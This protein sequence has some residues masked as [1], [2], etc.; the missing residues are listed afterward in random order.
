MALDGTTPRTLLANLTI[1][2]MPT[3]VVIGGLMPNTAY[4]IQAA[5]WTLMGLGPT[6]A[7]VVYKMDESASKKNPYPTDDASLPDG[8]DGGAR[9]D[10]ADGSDPP[11]QDVTQVMQQTWFILLLGGILLAVLCLFIGALIVR[12]TLNRK[13]ALTA[14]N[15]PDPATGVGMDPTGMMAA[16]SVRGRHEV[17]WSRNGWSTNAKGSNEIDVQA[18]L[19]PHGA[20]PL[21]T[22]PEYAELLDHHHQHHHQSADHCGG[23]G[24]VNQNLSLS[25]FLPRKDIF[26]RTNSQQ[27]PHPAAYATTTLVARRQNGGLVVQQPLQQQQLKSL[28]QHPADGCGPPTSAAF[29]ASD[30]SG[31]TTDELADRSR[32]NYMSTV[33]AAATAGTAHKNRMKLLP[34]L[35]ELL[36]P[37]PRH[38]PPSP[39]LGVYDPINTAE[40]IFQFLIDQL[41]FSK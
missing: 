18:T 31:Y 21:L 24:G 5:A 25:S 19:L 28:I 39:S 17:F 8:E 7:P 16:G 14:M 4:S 33:A 37:P 2:A 29:S 26:Q 23:G 11:N 20:Q 9:S 3:S 27:L 41:F 1:A 15:K 38:P 13:K 34:N 32:R 12:R 30:S 36:P 40:V 22:P 35:G 10:E 6:S